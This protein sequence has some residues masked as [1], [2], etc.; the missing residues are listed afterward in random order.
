MSTNATSLGR[1]TG[2]HP[3]RKASVD[4]PFTAEKGAILY[5]E[6]VEGIHR[7]VGKEFRLRGTE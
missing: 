5:T 7:A 6:Y 1:K 2:V 4:T 3:R